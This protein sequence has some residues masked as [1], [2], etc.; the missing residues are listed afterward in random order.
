M[1]L[2]RAI[3]NS[4]AVV[5]RGIV[6]FISKVQR[7]Q[8]AGAIAVVIVN[9][10]DSILECAGGQ[11]Q[12]IDMLSLVEFCLYSLLLWCFLWSLG[13]GDR[14]ITI[15]VVCVTRTS[16]RAFSL[17]A[18]TVVD[19]VF[20]E[21]DSPP[22]EDGDD[23]TSSVGR[24]DGSVVSSALSSSSS[25]SSGSGS[26][27]SGSSGSGSSGS[28]SRYESTSSRGGLH[29]LTMPCAHTFLTS[30]QTGSSHS[31]QGSSGSSGSTGSSRLGSSKNS[32]AS[33]SSGSSSSRP[34]SCLQSISPMFL[35]YMQYVHM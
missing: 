1:T 24:P 18:A 32:G 27:G 13:E 7:C 4:I 20:A 10:D 12:F 16:G 30:V 5:G 21:A 9:H 19:L 23:D 8:K 6:P 11:R 17:S 25:G 26:S 28:A 3:S 33:Q 34:V 15:P 14:E 29:T 35:Y 22:A 2:A 31:S